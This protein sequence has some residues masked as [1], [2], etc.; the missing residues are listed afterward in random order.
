MTTSDRAKSARGDGSKDLVEANVPLV[1][2]IVNR[3]AAGFPDH[4]DRS[5]LVQ[6]GVLGLIEASRRFD[7]DRGI[8]FSTFAG[9]RIE[10]AVLDVL[11]SRDWLSRS[12]RRRHNQLRREEDHLAVQLGRT[13]TSDDLAQSLGVDEDEVDGIRARAMEG[14]IDSLDRRVTRGDGDMQVSDSLADAGPGI[15][16]L[17]EDRETLSYLR[18]AIDLLPERERIVVIG[19]FFEGRSMTE[20]GAFLGVTQSRASQ[21][22]EAALRSLRHAI[23]AQSPERTTPTGPATA[24]Q[25]AMAAELSSRS[26]YSQRLTLPAPVNTLSSTG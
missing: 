11:R 21:L 23:E 4:V 8:A 14:V 26:S 15:E 19:Y 7:P 24:R 16:D 3:I 18:D 2:H 20:L 12:V 1:Q 10:G 5:D 25:A 22:K 9:R 17:L 13:P 6:A